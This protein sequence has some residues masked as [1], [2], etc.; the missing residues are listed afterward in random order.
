MLGFKSLTL[1]FYLFPSLSLSF[2]PLF[3]FLSFSLLH[4]RHYVSLRPLLSLSLSLS[5]SS[6]FP[7]FSVCELSL[8]NTLF[9]NKGKTSLRY[10]FVFFHALYPEISNVVVVDTTVLHVL[11]NSNIIKQKNGIIIFML[12][13]WVMQNKFNLSNSISVLC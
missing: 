8:T 3:F 1:S 2:T 5:L 4:T 13:I 9:L 11:R 12:K 10:G 6:L 7:L